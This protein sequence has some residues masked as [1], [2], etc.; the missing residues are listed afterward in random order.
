MKHHILIAEDD[1][2]IIELMSLYLSGEGFTIS[3]TSS[4]TKAIELIQ[5]EEIDIAL[6]DI[7]L[8]EMSGYELIK[9]I[10]YVSNL[11]IIILSAKDSDSDKILGLNI[12]ADAYLTKPFNPLEVIAYIKALLRRY[13][14]LGAEAGDNSVQ[15][16]VL[17]DLELDAQKF[18]LK[19]KG[20]IVPLTSTEFK[21]LKKMMESPERIFTKAQLYEAIN[22]KYY[23]ND[24]NTMMVHISNIRSKIEDNPA[25]PKYIV[26]VRGLGYRIENKSK[27]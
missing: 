24:D 20:N 27:T 16:Y 25:N 26:T 12:G 6:I 3:S 4:G 13:Y 15:K 8:P 17:G 21:I 10:R 9:K 2:D 18:I 7:M 19:K 1:K 5:N 23:E 22:G 14:Q 11:P